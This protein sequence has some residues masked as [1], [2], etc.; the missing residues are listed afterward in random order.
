MIDLQL[1]QPKSSDYPNQIVLMDFAGKIIQSTN[2][3]F[4]ATPFYQDSIVK[5]IPFLESIFEF[6]KAQKTEAPA[7]S[8][9]KVEEPFELL[10]GVY[11]FT[12]STLEFENHLLILW[13]IIDKTP[14]YAKVA[15]SQQLRNESEMNHSNK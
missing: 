15:K 3:I 9:K 12:F 1:Y 4:D 13:T 6:V 11:D 5:N 14:F 2:S 7:V 10:Q 8:F